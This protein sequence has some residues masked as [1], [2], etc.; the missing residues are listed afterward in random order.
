[1]SSPEITLDS[2]IV[3]VSFSGHVGASIRNSWVSTPSTVWK[4]KK[5]GGA[6]EKDKSNGVSTPIGNHRYKSART[7]EA[8]NQQFTP[9]G[10]ELPERLMPGLQFGNANNTGRASRNRQLR[11]FEASLG[12]GA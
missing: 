3:I 7:A 10:R 11:I 2:L 5:T 6:Y 8:V 4:V 12:N 1:M 9:F